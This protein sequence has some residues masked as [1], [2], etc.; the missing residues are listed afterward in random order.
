MLATQKVSRIS[1]HS[2]NSHRE[3]PDQR[4]PFSFNFN[5][6]SICSHEVLLLVLATILTHRNLSLKKSV[7]NMLSF[8]FDWD[9][10]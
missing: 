4:K 8:S 10:R 7:E 5:F 9:Q 2:L 3:P 6:Q 1:S